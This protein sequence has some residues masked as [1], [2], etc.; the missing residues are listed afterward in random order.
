MNNDEGL[1]FEKITQVADWQLRRKT[2][3]SWLLFV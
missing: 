2:T 3:I 1:V